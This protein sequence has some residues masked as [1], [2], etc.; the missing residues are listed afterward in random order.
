MDKAFVNLEVRSTKENFKMEKDMELE[1]C[2]GLIRRDM[3][4]NGKKIIK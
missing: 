3:R 2:C 4:V 1:L